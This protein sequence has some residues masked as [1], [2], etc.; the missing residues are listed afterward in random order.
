MG[1][2]ISIYN[3]LKAQFLRCIRKNKID[4]I[5][6]KII[7][8]DNPIHE[9]IDNISTKN[10]KTDNSI[11]EQKDDTISEHI[12]EKCSNEINKTT[13]IEITNTK[14]E[15]SKTNDD[16]IK[17]KL[18]DENFTPAVEISDDIIK[19][20]NNLKVIA[21]IKE[22]DKLWLDSSG[23]LSIHVSSGWQPLMRAAFGQSRGIIIPT[24][25][26]IITNAISSS[27]KHISEI[28]NMYPDV[29]TGLNNLKKSYSDKIL[30]IQT[31]V[32]LIDSAT[33]YPETL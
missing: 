32:Q 26:R 5:N 20:I 25:T 21:S 15:E 12:A 6:T 8:T 10:I 24:I 13:E 7:K 27:N 22:S 16:V 19:L 28:S 4:D 9:Q 31:L 14:M 3:Y 17:T 1:V 23:C 29:K 33:E 18:T 11:Y 30:E 2:I